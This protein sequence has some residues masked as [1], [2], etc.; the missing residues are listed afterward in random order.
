MTTS[1]TPT[2]LAHRFELFAERIAQVTGSLTAFVVATLFILLWAILGPLFKFSDNWLATIN[3]SATLI[4]FLMVFLIQKAQNKESIAVQ[5]KLNELIAANRGASN[6]LVSIENLTEEEL[7]VL[8][9][10]YRIMAEVT[11]QS[12]DLK[13]SHSIEEAIKESLEKLSDQGEIE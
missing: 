3:T 13:R 7:K 9:E 12:G 10:H 6:R 1:T 2:T 5:L 4:T 11:K 8:Q